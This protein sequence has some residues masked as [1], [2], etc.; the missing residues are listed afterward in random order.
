MG[1]GTY[2]RMIGGT[3]LALPRTRYAAVAG[4]HGPAG[5]GGPRNWEDWEVSAV[6]IILA[7][8][9]LGQVIRTK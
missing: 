2:D 8:R 4:Q 9:S 1:G 5:T 7:S 6:I 3:L